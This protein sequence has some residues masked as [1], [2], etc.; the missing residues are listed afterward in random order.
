M[1]QCKN[2]IWTRKKNNSD[3]SCEKSCQIKRSPLLH[4]ET[5]IWLQKQANFEFNLPLLYNTNTKWT[6]F[7][8]NKNTESTSPLESARYQNQ[9]LKNWTAWFSSK[10]NCDF[11]SVAIL[12][13]KT[14]PWRNTKF[15]VRKTFC[16]PTLAISLVQLLNTAS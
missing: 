11:S 14:I 15:H 8:V 4:E 1:H 2:K 3:C 10:N 12:K 13:T 7:S 6:S 5:K 9:G 16:P